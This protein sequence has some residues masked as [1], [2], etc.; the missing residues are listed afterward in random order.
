MEHEPITGVWS[1]SPQW[2]PGAEPL[3]GARGPSPPDA[4]SFCTLLY[5]R[6]AK[7]WG[8]EWNDTN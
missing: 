5:N 6:R 2:G 4:E 1:R 3:V 8:F 7:S